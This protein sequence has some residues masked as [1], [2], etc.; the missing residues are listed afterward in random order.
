MN[1]IKADKLKRFMLD[2]TM[3][4]AVYEVVQSAFLRGRGLRDVQLLAAERLALDLL[5][6]AWS[7][8]ERFKPRENGESPPLKQV[9]L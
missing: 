9:G 6:D 1:E 7:E 2:E 5:E 4:D 3:S 8:L